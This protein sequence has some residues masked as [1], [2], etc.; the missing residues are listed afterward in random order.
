ME[1]NVEIK[2]K[3][4]KGVLNPEASTVKRALNLLGYKE[5]LDVKTAK[6]IRLSVEAENEEKARKLV[7]DMCKRLLVNPVI[8]E[9]EIIIS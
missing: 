9:Y 3:L 5:V 8:E 2:V 4:K 6:I 7:G 1:F